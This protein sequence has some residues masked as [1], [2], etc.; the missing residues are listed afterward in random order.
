MITFKA[1]INLAPFPP[2]MK[3]GFIAKESQLSEDQKFRLTEAAWEALGAIYSARLQKMF[4]S[5]MQ[6][7]A[8][9]KKSYDPND[10]QEAKTKLS[11][12]FAQK[13]ESASTQEDIELVRKQLET[14][15]KTPPS[16]TTHNP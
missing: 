9:G 4:A 3:A 1:I 10:F 11:F 12:E 14:H 15:I 6:E 16:P 8:E 2:D 7:M 5:M 13:L